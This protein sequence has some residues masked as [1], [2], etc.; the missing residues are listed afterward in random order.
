MQLIVCPVL[1]ILVFL[2]RSW[3]F[4]DYIKTF[5]IIFAKKTKI[6]LGF[7][8]KNA[9]FALPEM[10]FSILSWIEMGPKIIQTT[11]NCPRDASLGPALGL[12]KIFK[13]F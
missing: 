3:D 10:K 11:Y 12:G 4:L 8:D 6:F 5:A 7:L 1:V 2:R 9:Q 13:I